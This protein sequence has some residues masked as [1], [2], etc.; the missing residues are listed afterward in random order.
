[1][2]LLRWVALSVAERIQLKV[3]V[4]SFQ[5]GG[6]KLVFVLCNHIVSVAVSCVERCWTDTIEST[7]AFLS[8][9]RT[10]IDCFDVCADAGWDHSPG[11]Q[12]VNPAL[13]EEWRRYP[14]LA[15]SPHSTE[16]PSDC[17]LLATPAFSCASALS[18]ALC[19]SHV[20]VRLLQA[21]DS[22]SS[23]I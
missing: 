20:Y 11:G 8:K 2:L 10:E 16:A 3:H 6:L 14:F 4:P 15:H 1:L 21:V 22:R 19:F 12:K 23:R 18:S 9:W 17:A 7:C 13:E 5:S